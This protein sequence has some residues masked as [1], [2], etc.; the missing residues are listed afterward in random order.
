MLKKSIFFLL[1]SLTMA[2]F[3]AAGC[4]NEETTD[5]KTDTGGD[6]PGQLPPIREAEGAGMLSEG[7]GSNIIPTVI[8]SNAKFDTPEVQ[9]FVELYLEAIRNMPMFGRSARAARS[10]VFHGNHGAVRIG[11]ESGGNLDRDGYSYESITNE[12]FDF[13]NTDSLFLGGSVGYLNTLT[14]TT[15]TEQANGIIRFTGKF[16]GSIHFENITYNVKTKNRTRGN[17]YLLSG[18]ARVNLPDSL[19]KAFCYMPTKEEIEV[20]VKDTTPDFRK[21]DSISAEIPTSVTLGDIVPLLASVLPWDATNRIIT[22]TATGA[23]I[24]ANR[25]II[26]DQAGTARITATIANG[27]AQNRAYTQSWTVRVVSK[28]E[29]VGVERIRINIPSTVTVG[30]LIVPFEAILEPTVLP[31]NATDQSI[32]WSAEGATIAPPRGIPVSISFNT[33]GTATLTATI[34]KGRLDGKDTI[35]FTQSWRIEVTPP[36]DTIPTFVP[37]EEIVIAGE[38]PDTVTRGTWVSFDEL[39]PRVIPENATNKEIEWGSINATINA[40]SDGKTI[41]MF[42]SEGA[43]II[44]ATIMNGLGTGRN[45]T[46]SWTVTVTARDTIPNDTTP[47]FIP[48]SD[49]QAIFPDS[50]EAG[51]NVALR[52][53]VIPQNATNRAIVWTAVG[54]TVTANSVMFD[55]AGTA[56]ITATVRNGLSNEQSPMGADGNRLNDFSRTWQVTVI[57]PDTTPTFI[58][59]TNIREEFPLTM[60]TNSS[61]TLAGTVIPENATN[62]KTIHW[63]VNG[64][65]LSFNPNTNRGTWSNNPHTAT[66]TATILNGASPTENYVQSW[67]VQVVGDTIPNDTIPTFVPVDSIQLLQPL[68][69]T[70]QIDGLSHPL[71]ATVL[72]ENATN[73]NI[74]WTA[75]GATITV[76]PDTVASEIRRVAMV[77]FDQAGTA[78][79]TATIQ[80]GASTTQNYTQSWTVLVTAKDTIPNDTIPKDTT[81]FIPVS[82][83]QAFFP[84]SAEAGSSVALRAEVIPQN[85]TNTTIVWTANNA[86]IAANSVIFDAAGIAVITATVRNGLSNEQSPMGADGNRL[87][88]FSRTW[89]VTVIKPDTTPTF[90]P[91]S[92]I[93]L[94]QPLPTTTKI[95][96][97]SHPLTATVL[98][99][100][101]TNQTIEWSATGATITAA[102]ESRVAMV[103]FDQA[104]TARVTATIRSGTSATQN[105]TQS[106]T[107]QVVGDTIPGDTTTFVPVREIDLLSFPSTVHNN[108]GFYLET[109]S[110]NVLPANATNKIIEWSAVGATIVEEETGMQIHWGNPGTATITATI[111]NGK[112]STEDYVQSWNVTVTQGGGGNDTIPTII[113]VREISGNLELQGDRIDLTR[114]TVLPENATNK[115]I[116]WTTNPGG[117]QIIMGANNEPAFIQLT[118]TMMALGMSITVTATIPSGL[119]PTMPYTQNWTITVPGGTDPTFVPVQRIEGFDFPQQIVVGSNA[120]A[121]VTQAKI[122]PENATNQQ[123]TINVSGAMYEQLSGMVTFNQVGTATITATIQNGTAVGTNFVETW[124]VQVTQGGGGNDTTSNFVPVVIIEAPTIQL[125]VNVGGVAYLTGNLGR[126][127]VRPENAT[128]QNIT[129]NVS[130]ANYQATSG[131]VMFNQA[132][133]ATITATIVNGRSPTENYTQTWQ[134]LV[135]QPTF[136]PVQRIEGFDFPQQIVV[137]GNAMA[138]NTQAKVVPEN[139]TNQQVTINVSGAMYEQLSGMITFNQVGTATITATIQN[140][141]AVGTNFVETWTVQVTQGGGGTDPVFVPVQN[142]LVTAFESPTGGPVPP[143]RPGSQLWITFSMVHVTPMNA[144]NQDVMFRIVSGN[145]KVW[146]GSVPGQS[147]IDFFAPAGNVIVE[148]YVENGTRNEWGDLIEFTKTFVVEVR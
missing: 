94:Q 38:I 7:I 9:E 123:V 133:T 46:Q 126:I 62:G 56:L 33:L 55:A 47:T 84:D 96:G 3:F 71:A 15:K 144:T 49:I 72:P 114:M 121:R 59:V 142:I 113:P 25:R 42:D 45:Y 91:V 8:P 130:G 5:D 14:K 85:A 51:T 81:T 140:G 22:W 43:A 32:E 138:R 6:T 36:N 74:E 78:T 34:A 24:D 92:D 117:A 118:S 70:T 124:T 97:M 101:A 148:A 37:V 77:T 10:S 102:S 57:K 108:V 75:T 12:F 53:E 109:R 50:A 100:N 54:A 116:T 39:Q 63:T 44:T 112:S 18:E 106:W 58:P 60:E 137:G 31:A 147:M 16:R 80:S 115:N 143:Q 132:G 41:L 111:R 27:T 87:S 119:S 120:M 29:F 141:T 76:V 136:I 89:Q 17:F 107:V 64:D 23:K 65:V 127:V 40:S 139:A 67:T 122:V 95:D 13:S 30:T 129:W 110:I 98:P 48:V 73:Q 4:S 79:V 21:V 68:P 2:M 28:D 82:D 61:F 26:F 135:T 103:T 93:Q 35:A 125:Q 20:I 104:G 19:I 90:V 134:V 105:F 1:L 52:A 145:A 69:T 146:E 86:T 131:M 83:I 128:N 66:I 88:D 99:S 11:F